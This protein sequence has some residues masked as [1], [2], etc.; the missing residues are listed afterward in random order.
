MKKIILTM[1]TS[2]FVLA[3]CQ[4]NHTKATKPTHPHSQQK[5]TIETKSTQAFPYQNLL[6]QD[7]QSY[8]LLVIGANDEQTPIEKN[9][10]VTEHV[11]SILS[12]PS[13][14]IVKKA[15][16]ELKI[17]NKVSYILFNQKG[18]VHQARNLKELTSFLQ[19]N[20]L[21]N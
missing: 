7:E 18:I 4:S 9:Q 19:Q 1:L 12:L 3:G 20:P 10:T 6:A 2:L 5:K 13:E 11:K 16:P 15:Y 14:E 8:S 21:A 17:S